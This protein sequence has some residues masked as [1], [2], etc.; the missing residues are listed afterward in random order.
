[1]KF[2]ALIL[3]PALSLLAG[4]FSGLNSKAAPEQRYLLQSEIVKPALE[5]QPAG[6][7][8]VLRPSASPGVAG[9]RIA[10]VRS[11]ARVDYYANA[12]WVEETPPLLQSKIIDALR[13]GGRFATVESDTE[14]FA[15]QY[16]LSVDIA[17][18]QAKYIDAGAPTVFV[19][20]NCTLGRRTDRSVIVS[21]AA[22]GTAHASADHLEAVVAAFGA[23]TSQALQQIAENI[24]PPAA[25]QRVK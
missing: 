14:P 21:F 25:D 19:T 4:C 6:T 10:V 11:G 3:V 8:Q 1:V 22:Q 7:V 16:L 24:A 15:A 2:S 23:A 20:L 12:R 13:T 18:F 5:A 9:S 17:N